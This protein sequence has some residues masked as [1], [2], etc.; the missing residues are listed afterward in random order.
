MAITPSYAPL[1][2]LAS[3]AEGDKH[4]YAIRRDVIERTA[5]DVRLGS[6]TLYRLLGQ[7]R[8]EGYIGAARVRPAR[9]LDDERRQYFRITAAGRRALGSELRRLVRVL[10]AAKPAVDSRSR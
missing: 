10:M 9:H 8:D 3:L 4:G 6:T 7:L 1:L 2:I 5:G